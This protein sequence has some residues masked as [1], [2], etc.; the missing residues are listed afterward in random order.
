MYVYKVWEIISKSRSDLFF[1]LQL[2][3]NL[4][5]RNSCTGIMHVFFCFFLGGVRF[6]SYT[7]CTCKMSN[8]VINVGTKFNLPICRYSL[9]PCFRRQLCEVSERNHPKISQQ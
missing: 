8:A 9:V 3:Q 1:R 2:L 6:W 7:V 4:A 5:Q